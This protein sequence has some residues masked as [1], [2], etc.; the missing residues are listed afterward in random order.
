VSLV[1][2]MTVKASGFLLNSIQAVIYLGDSS[3]FSSSRVLAAILK[4]FAERYDGEVQTIPSE[5]VTGLP[6]DVP[7]IVL[8]SK[9]NTWELRVAPNRIDSIWRSITNESLP[10][11]AVELCSDVVHK[12]M[13]EVRPPVNRIALVVIRY[14]EVAEPARTLAD[15]FCK[16]GAVQGPFRNTQNFEI[17]NHKQYAL[18]GGN[19]P[20]NSW[21]RCRTGTIAGT[22]TGTTTGTDK[23]IILVEQDINTTPEFGEI[24]R[25]IPRDVFSFFQHVKPEIDSILRLYFPEEV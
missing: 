11:T 13:Q 1:S 21:V 8:Q 14:C 19:Y 24:A 6:L 3:K 25:F 12:Y 22:T 7:R 9:D 4:H 20:V 5:L 17:H 16:L 2:N 10:S 18:P 15:H 23:S